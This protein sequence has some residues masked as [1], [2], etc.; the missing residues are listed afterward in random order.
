MG[1]AIGVHGFTN[2]AVKG[3]EATSAKAVELVQVGTTG[4]GKPDS[5]DVKIKFLAAEALHGIRGLVF[6]AQG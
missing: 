4:L 6:D 1:E 2:D 3:S 5:H